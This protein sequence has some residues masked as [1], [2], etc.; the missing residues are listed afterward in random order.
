MMCRCCGRELPPTS[1]ERF[2]GGTYRKMCWQCRWVLNGKGVRQR[3]ILKKAAHDSVQ[4]VEN[5]V[6]GVHESVHGVEKSV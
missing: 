4:A 1:F 2:K 6:Q 5:S 3:S